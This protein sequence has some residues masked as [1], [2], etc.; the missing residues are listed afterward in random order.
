[1][2]MSS[3]ET[4]C[5]SSSALSDVQIHILKNSEDLLQFASDLSHRE[6]LVFVPGQQSGTVVLAARR[7]PLLQPA[8]NEEN[9]KKVGTVYAGYEEPVALKVLKTGQMMQGRREVDYGRMEPLFAYPFIDNGGETIAVIAFVGAVESNRDMLTETAFLALQVPIERD[10]RKL[11]RPLSVQDGVVLINCNGVIIYA[12]EMAESILH[13]RGYSGPLVGSNIYNRQTNLTGAKQALATREG[14]AEDLTF[15]EV[16]VTRRV[17]PLLRRG[18]VYRVIAILTERTEL[19]RKEEELMIKTSVIKEI[20]H[21]VKNNLQTIASLLRMQMRRTAS[22]EAKQVLQ[23]SVNRILSISLV[24]EILSHHDE[25]SIDISA[26]AEQLLALLAHSMASAECCVRTSFSGSKLLLPSD[27]ATSLAL[28]LNE[29]ITNAI[30]HGLAGCQEGE[31]RVTVACTGNNCVL[32]VADTGRGMNMA[33]NDSRESRQHLGLTI[34]RT[35]VEKDLRGTLSFAQAV[36]H[37]T[38]VSIQFSIAE[39]G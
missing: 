37:G 1:M 24:H 8:E 33:L 31:L 19:Y 13:M 30:I 34:V 15:G 22:R 27:Q 32:T 28:V 3:I 7:F 35:L 36:P 39:R 23:E 18:K 17:I 25:E 4:I 2:R 26:V 10:F 6:I 9:K 20:H 16:V 14:F 5:H 11:Y 38:E 29:L 12:D 21:R